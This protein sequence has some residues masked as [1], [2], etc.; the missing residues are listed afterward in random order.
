MR[1][2][3]SIREEHGRRRKRQVRR[4]ASERPGGDAEAGNEKMTNGDGEEIFTEKGLVLERKQLS[5]L[6]GVI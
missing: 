6:D 1:W 2:M 5:H 3:A 4:K